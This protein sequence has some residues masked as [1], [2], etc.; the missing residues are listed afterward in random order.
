MIEEKGRTASFD[1]CA[2]LGR[3]KVSFEVQP[4]AGHLKIFESLHSPACFPLHW[5]TQL[6]LLMLLGN[7]KFGISPI[8]TLTSGGNL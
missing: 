6:R 1:G 5:K 8:W 2:C 7:L 3:L 4:K